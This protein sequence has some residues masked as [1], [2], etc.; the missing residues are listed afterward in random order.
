MIRCISLYN[1]T[2][3]SLSVKVGRFLRVCVPW[4][5]SPIKKTDR[6]DDVSIILLAVGLKNTHS[7]CTCI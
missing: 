7:K 5:T 1:I 6:H 3:S 4:Y 2:V